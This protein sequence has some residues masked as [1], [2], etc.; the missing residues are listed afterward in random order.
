[1]ANKFHAKKTSCAYGHPHDSKKEAQRCNELHLLQE[2]GIISDLQI[3]VPFDLL[4]FTEYPKLTL[5]RRWLPKGCKALGN[6]R[7]ITYK[8]DFVYQAE[9]FRI[10]E[11][12]KGKRTPDYILKR[13]MFRSLYCKNGKM[14][15][16]ET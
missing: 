5:P 10:V 8:A 9:G 7:K 1:M 15:F 6:E 16:I 3:Q 14:V 12:V 4:P 2:E 11:D 13:K